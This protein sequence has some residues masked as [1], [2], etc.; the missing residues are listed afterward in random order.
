MRTL[1]TLLAIFCFTTVTHALVTINGIVFTAT[2]DEQ[3]SVEWD[4]GPFC[5]NQAVVDGCEWQWELLD[6]PHERVVMKGVTLNPKA[7]FKMPRSGLYGFRVKA[8]ADPHCSGWAF[9]VLS[10]DGVVNSADQ[11]WMLYGHPAAPG[12][13]GFE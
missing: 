8:C 2:T 4:P 7:N 13:I 1:M 11:G 10:E 9:S 5:L 12:G 6:L 3:I